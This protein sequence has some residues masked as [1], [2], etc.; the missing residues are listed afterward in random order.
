MYNL[1][2]LLAI[3]VPLFLGAAFIVLSVMITV[4]IET[5]II[6]R[7]GVLDNRKYIKGVNMLT[8]VIHNM[9]LMTIFIVTG[10]IMK[11]S[12]VLKIV[13]LAWV[14]IA[15]FALIPISEAYAYKK[16]SKME[17]GKI[18]GYSYLANLISF[19]AGLAFDALMTLLTIGP[20][21]IVF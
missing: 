11:D 9:I 18:I 14:V 16:L 12:D 10:L 2:I 15:E 17:M 20:L 5:P 4:W 8:N 6:L 3:L 7:L 21:S 13:A 19:V 1:I